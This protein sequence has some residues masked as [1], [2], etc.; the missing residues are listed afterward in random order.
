MGEMEV[1]RLQEH[2][3]RFERRLE[4]LEIENPTMVTNT[5]VEGLFT[6]VP[7]RADFDWTRV[8]ELDA[9]KKSLLGQL[10]QDVHERIEQTVA[11]LRIG[12]SKLSQAFSDNQQ[13]LN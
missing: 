13:N 6:N 9:L 1:R 4:S 5:S 3:M 2:L 12:L 7:Q 11:E 8:G 10:E